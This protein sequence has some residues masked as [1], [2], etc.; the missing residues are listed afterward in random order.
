[1][2]NVKMKG[3]YAF[4]TMANKKEAEAAIKY[5]DGKEFRGKR[6]SVEK[7]GEKKSE[8]TVRLEREIRSL[9]EKLAKSEKMVEKTEARLVKAEERLVK[10]EEKLSKAEEKVAEMEKLAEAEKKIAEMEVA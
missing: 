9:R 6:I 3:A 7:A 1:M 8:D 10:A 4:V 2:T 5:R